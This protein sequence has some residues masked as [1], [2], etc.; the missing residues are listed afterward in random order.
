LNDE[1]RTI[2]D[3]PR[4]LV[5]DD[6][7]LVLDSIRYALADDH[8]VTAITSPRAALE[9]LT[10]G[11]FQILITDLM[12]AEMRG[13]ELIR[14]VHSRGLKLSVIMITAF[15]TKETAIEAL[16]TGA[17]DFLEKPLSPR[18]LRRAVERAWKS[19]QVELENQQ[20][21][22]RLRQANRA[23][24]QANRDL[25]EAAAFAELSPSPMIRFLADGRVSRANT[26]ARTIFRIPDD[27]HGNVCEVFPALAGIDLPGFIGSPQVLSSEHTLGD[28]AYLVV[29]KSVPELGIGH[30][31]ASDLTE[32]KRAE[33][34]LGQS[35]RLEAVGRLAAGVAHDFNNMLMV[36][37]LVTRKLLEEVKE[38]EVRRNAELIGEA[39]QRAADIVRQLLAFSRRSVISPEPLQ[40]NAIV[41]GLEKLL[42]HTVGEG[43]TLRVEL[44]PGLALVRQDRTQMEQVVTNLVL[45]ARD[46]T[47][48]G[49]TITV[50]TANRRLATPQGDLLPGDYVGLTVSD[51]GHG[52]PAA[53]RDRVFEPFFTTKEPGKGTGMGLAT[54]H[55]IAKRAGGTV[56]LES[57]EGAG[58]SFTVLLPAF[59]QNAA[60]TPSD[61]HRALGLPRGNGEVILLVEDETD[62]REQLSLAIERQGYR[63]LQAR[64]GEEG[65]SRAEAY[66]G[67]LDLVLT[68]VIMPGISGRDMAGR[69]RLLRGRLPVI[70]MSGHTEE[71]LGFHPEDDS[72]LIGKPFTLEKLLDRVRAQ[73]QAAA[74]RT[75]SS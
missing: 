36:I 19:L 67:P 45:N 33:Q 39:S 4:I 47:P 62:V 18:T 25:D 1:V 11:T 22:Q 10:T 42:G 75:L 40:L 3:R 20:L 32:L 38:G 16:Q 52:I 65:L 51:T 69:L 5:L 72:E 31:Y 14:E 35:Q 48:E 73:L 27:G 7:E 44:D 41:G 37:G 2:A 55:G 23:L 59:E 9:Q 46:A 34:R 17:F 71:V 49:G 13:T 61:L 24:L 58:S 6:D 53:I 50:K 54:I 28:R 56:W 68:D 26:A 29:L 64:S 66:E 63:V 12:M 15:G 57:E 70:Y 60:A 21:L 43:V 8:D 30:L 74:K